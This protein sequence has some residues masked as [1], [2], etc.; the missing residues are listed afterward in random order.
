[1]PAAAT[2]DAAA[3]SLAAKRRVDLLPCSCLH[4][5]TDRLTDHLQTL[6]DCMQSQAKEEMELQ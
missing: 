6:A 3:M 4:A 2:T 1:M 5:C